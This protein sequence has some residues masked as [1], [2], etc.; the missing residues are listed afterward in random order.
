LKSINVK[1]SRPSLQ[2]STFW[3]APEVVK[4]IE[5]TDKADIWSLGCL[6]VEM[7]T[8][9]HPFPQFSQM[10]ALFQIGSNCTPDIPEDISDD[11][12]DF[13]KMTFDV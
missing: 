5:T 12:K 1:S 4:Q 2:G 3:M 6:V 11:A 13:L 7:F 8:G 10:Q 9:T